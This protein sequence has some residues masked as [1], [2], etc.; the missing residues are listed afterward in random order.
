MVKAVAHKKGGQIRYFGLPGVETKDLLCWGDLCEYV[1]AVEVFEDQFSTL[2]RK[3]NTQFSTFRHR[4]HYGDVDDVI[5]KNMSKPR[6]LSGKRTY[7][8]TTFLQDEGWV[9]DFDVIYLDYFGKFLPYNRGGRV[10]RKRANALRRLFDLDRQDA[11]QSWLL[12][13]TVESKLY[14]VRDRNRMRK[15][16]LDYGRTTND[17]TRNIINFLLAEDIDLDMQAARLVHGTLSN[18]IT[19]AAANSDVKISP[20]PTVI[21]TGSNKTPML[22]F[23]YEVTP[24]EVL[25]GMQ[26][27]LLLL[28]SPFLRVIGGD[29][30]LSFQLLA[31]QPPGQTDEVLRESFAFLG[32][33]HMNRLL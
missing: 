21:Y 18:I 27:S 33:E 23:A 14:D 17:E 24:Q 5:L 11:R 10:V 12:I 30:D 3:L 8:S 26:D 29:G 32:E 4:A 2:A 22:H 7:V 6:G 13:L 16:L 19:A 15:F 25:S 1:A 9:W 20:K 28:R 31:D